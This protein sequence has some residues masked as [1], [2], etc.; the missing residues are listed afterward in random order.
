MTA[1]NLQTDAKEKGLPWSLAKGLKTFCPLSKFIPFSQIPDPHNV[2][3][4]L[5]VNGEKRQEDFTNLMLFDIPRLLRHVTSVVPLQFGD[6]LLTGTPK[7]VGSVKPGDKIT[8]GVRV[9]GEELQEG[10]IEVLV[11][12]REGGYGS[13]RDKEAIE[14]GL[15]TPAK[16]EGLE[17]LAE[18]EGLEAPAKEA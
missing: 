13:E 5:E 11:V 2:Q 4:H 6:M 17:A 10:K 8:A 16:E 9:D 14:K 18:E 15:E 3:L 12:E 7:G 1:R